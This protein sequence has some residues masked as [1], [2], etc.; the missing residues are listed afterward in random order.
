MPLSQHIDELRKRLIFCFISI[1]IFSIIG[2]INYNDIAGLIIKPFESII[3]NGGTL[4][5]SSIYE[6][7]FVKLKLSL[8]SGVILS[9][10]IM[11]FQ[12]CRFIL[13]GL[14][15]NEKK[16]LF[17]ILVVSSILA[18]TSTYLGYAIIFPYIIQ[19][20]LNSKFIPE[21]INILLNFQQNTTYI[22][23]FL[24]GSIIIFQSPILLTVLLAKNIITR[25][26]L[27]KNSRWFIVG[28]CICSAIVT[29]PDIFSQLMLAGPLLTCY[30][31]CIL[32]AKLMKWG[33][34]CSE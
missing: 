30:F 7:F 11:L 28:I 4:N 13:P 34:S 15:K 19:F 23:S 27:W 1:I 9:L 31:F 17:I 24:T 32:L 16:W 5:V 12:L 6:G 2:Y 3:S 22:I 25:S 8:I 26:F 33:E 18:S 29:P 20:L 21:N 14:K 10:P